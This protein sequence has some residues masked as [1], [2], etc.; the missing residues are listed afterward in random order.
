MAIIR[1]KVPGFT[2]MRA[3]VMFAHGMA[4][5]NN[6]YLIDWFNEHG[7]IVENP[8]EEAKP[9]PVEIPATERKRNTRKKED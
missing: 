9:E 6:Q 7:Y 8:V 3:G 5:T 2:G 1:T 4:E